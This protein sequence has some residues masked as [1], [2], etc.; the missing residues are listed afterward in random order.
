MR[1]RGTWYLVKTLKVDTDTYTVVSNTD[2]LKHTL[3]NP[4]Y[5][6]SGT[7]KAE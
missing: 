1:S 6:S 3:F 7:P 4:V 2:T 5:A